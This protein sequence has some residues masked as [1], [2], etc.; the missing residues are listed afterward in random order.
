MCATVVPRTSGFI[1][2]AVTA[3]S[4]MLSVLLPRE[5]REGTNRQVK[6]WKNWQERHALAGRGDRCWMALLPFVTGTCCHRCPDERNAAAWPLLGWHANRHLKSPASLS[7][8]R[9]PG[10][11]AG[12]GLTV[13]RDRDRRDSASATGVIV[14]CSASEVLRSPAVEFRGSPPL[15]SGR[16]FQLAQTSTWAGMNRGE[17]RSSFSPSLIN[18]TPTSG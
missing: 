2:G 12:S 3:L 1:L 18:S 7:A 9:G 6:G 15:R 8:G 16:A 17:P 11:P 13:R 5:R 4:C 14:S 10:R